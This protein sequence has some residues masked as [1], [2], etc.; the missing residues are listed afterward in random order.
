ML[1]RWWPRFPLF[2]EKSMTKKQWEEEARDRF[3]TFLH[4]ATGI[5]YRTDAEDV[6]VEGG[7]NFDYRLRPLD[8]NASPIALELF[9]LTPS[10]AELAQNSVWIEIV[11][12]L[13]KDLQTRGVKGYLIH[14]PHFFVPKTRRK[15]FVRDLA[16]NL[17]NAIAAQPQ[18]Q[19]FE[20]HGYRITQIPGLGGVQFS[21]MGPGGAFDPAS[22]ATECLH[23]KI[24]YKNEQLNISGCTRAILIVNWNPLVDSESVLLACSRFNF[25]L[26]TNIDKVYF[27]V[28]EGKPHVVFDRSIYRAVAAG[29]VEAGHLENALY[30]Q[31]IEARLADHDVHAFDVVKKITAQRESIEWLSENAYSSLV[32]IAQDFLKKEDIDNALWVV[33]HLRS[34]AQSDIKALLCWPL[35]MLVVKNRPDL[36]PEILDILEGYAKDEDEGVRAHVPIPLAELAARRRSKN[37]DGTEFMT[38]EIG[39][40]TRAL[41]FEMLLGASG[42]LAE[43]MSWVFRSIRDVSDV[44]AWDI[45][46]SLA[47]NISREREGIAV[48]MIYHAIYRKRHF[49]ELGPFDSERLSQFL[50]ETLRSGPD[51]LRSTLVWSMGKGLEGEIE[52]HDVLPYLSSATEGAYER[53]TFTHL[54]RIVGEQLKAGNGEVCELFLKALRCEKRYLQEN[55]RA[56]VW[57]FEE[58]FDT[59]RLST[60]CWGTEV[61]GEII[62][63]LCS[64]ADGLGVTSEYIRKLKA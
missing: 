33:R 42:E 59:V 9:R 38:V 54:Y 47:T 26:F 40:R 46:R 30:L 6:P 28:A 35:Q 49:P 24:E 36:Y 62:E 43:R 7:K 16:E 45:V 56:Q 4:D 3:V 31:L 37:D 2:E 63:M 55:P 12:Q 5:S 15:T 32:M 39:Q 19:Q 52:I 44:E 11:G 27:E 60:R 34:T 17:S 23:D 29:D 53:S 21:T 64:M 22:I 8:S 20:H 1:T 14:T 61:A 51:D 58:F 25:S 50:A 10:K 48:L 57:H 41:A 13:K 18:A